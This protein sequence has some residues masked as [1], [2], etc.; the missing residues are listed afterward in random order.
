MGK[1]FRGFAAFVCALALLF[2]FDVTPAQAASEV[3]VQIDGEFLYDVA[4]SM[5]PLINE[6]RTGDDAWYLDQSN[7]KVRPG[8]I[9][10]L[11]Y[12]YNLENTAMLRALEI[13]VYFSHTRPNG[14]SWS[15]AHSGRYTMGENIAYGYG[16]VESVFTAFR[17]DD[18]KYAGQGHRR[19]M[20]NKEFTRVGFGCVRVDGVLYWAQEFGNGAAGGDGSKR[21]SASSVKAK[22]G[23]ISKA[24]AKFK[25]DT[26]EIIVPVGGSIDVPKVFITSDS[27]AKGTV[28]KAKW[29]SKKKKIAKV[30]S[31][32]VKGVKEGETKLTLD[33]GGKSLKVKVKVVP[34][35]TRVSGAAVPI[36]DYDTPLG[37][38]R[39]EVF[40]VDDE[41]PGFLEEGAVPAEPEEEEPEEPEEDDAAEDDE[42][43]NDPE[44]EEA[45]R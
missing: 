25:T 4:K 30:K 18:E 1:W 13:A 21:F 24:G 44:V 36:D 43:D 9:K 7:N 28:S 14:K 19:N 33:L 27:G 23:T 10:K 22:L 39:P 32:K 37:V 26:K 40:I 38:E 15:S 17:E 11:K 35:G 29:T 2:S 3:S 16:T 8:G 5:L 45:V 31:G 12:D 41:E 34:E 6:F 42:A 20:L